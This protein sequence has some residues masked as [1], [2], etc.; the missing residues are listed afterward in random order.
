[1][2]LLIIF[3]SGDSQEIDWDKTIKDFPTMLDYVGR[4]WQFVMY[5]DG[6]N[7]KTDLECF[8]SEIQP[9]HRDYGRPSSSFYELTN[10]KIGEC[11]CGAKKLGYAD[12]SLHHSLWCPVHGSKKR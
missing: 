3:G 4:K 1:M 2:R 8:F 11:E 5:Q 10:Q 7:S 9:D 12:Y 6:H